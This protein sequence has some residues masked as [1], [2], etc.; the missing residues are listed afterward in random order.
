MINLIPF[1]Y[2]SNFESLINDFENRWM[3]RLSKLQ[4]PKPVDVPQLLPVITDLTN[5]CQQLNKQNLQMQ[6]QLTTI[7]NR[8]QTIQTKANN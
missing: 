3:T 1:S 2:F 8:I 6:Q 4:T 5:V 7:A